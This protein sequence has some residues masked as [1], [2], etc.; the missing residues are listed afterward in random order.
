MDQR[1]HASAADKTTTVRI[2]EKDQK[3]LDEVVNGQNV[4]KAEIIGEALRDFLAASS[5][6]STEKMR[7]FNHHVAQLKMV[8]IETETERTRLAKSHI[9]SEDEFKAQ[10]HSIKAEA[11]AKLRVLED[12]NSALNQKLEKLTRELTL[13]NEEKKERD[14]ELARLGQH[15]G[16]L[17]KNS[18]MLELR[19]HEL[20]SMIDK[21]KAQLK[22]Y[23]KLKSE[24]RELGIANAKLE[25]KLESLQKELGDLRSLSDERLDLVTRTMRAEKEAEIQKREKI[26]AELKG[27]N[28]KLL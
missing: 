6:L 11:D 19:N 24:T 13:V 27:S 26:I 21:L 2:Y 4:S 22:D 17:Q 7:A 18:S 28:N 15:Q 25:M 9:Y 14:K 3:A 5:S 1:H 23:E 10:T 12:E 8:F 20:D 16:V